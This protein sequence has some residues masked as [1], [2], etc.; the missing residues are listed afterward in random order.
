MKRLSSPGTNGLLIGGAVLAGWWAWGWQGLILAFTLI[1]FWSLLQFRRATRALQNAANRPIG[2]IDSVTMMQ[3]RLEPGQQ[4]AE[5][6]QISGS[7]GIQQGDRDEWQWSDA[8]GNEIV[9]TFRRGV[10]VRWA[11]ARA[12]RD[13]GGNAAAPGASAD[14]PVQPPSPDARA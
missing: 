7:L 11:V 9:V 5:V 14:E 4:M 3:A 10:V 2:Q 8:G 1:V 12:D 13:P 6:L